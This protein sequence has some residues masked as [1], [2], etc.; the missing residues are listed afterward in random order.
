MNLTLQILVGLVAVAIVIAIRI[1]LK[2]GTWHTV[3][4]QNV[5]YISPQFVGQMV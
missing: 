5:T 3:N 4:V 2:A 1:V